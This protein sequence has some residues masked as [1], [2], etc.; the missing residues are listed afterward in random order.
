MAQPPWLVPQHRGTRRTHDLSR[1]GSLERQ[2]EATPRHGR[3]ATATASTPPGPKPPEAMEDPSNCPTYSRKHSEAHAHH[4]SGLSR[5]PAPFPHAGGAQAAVHRGQCSKEPRL[6]PRRHHRARHR[7]GKLFPTLIGWP[8]RRKTTPVSTTPTGT[9][10]RWKQRL[11]L[12][13]HSHMHPVHADH[14][15]RVEG[16]MRFTGRRRG[17]PWTSARV[18]RKPSLWTKPSRSPRLRRG[19]TIAC[20]V[21]NPAR[22]RLA[23][24]EPNRPSLDPTRVDR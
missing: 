13:S 23:Q 9:R 10:R 6:L 3:S 11:P 8:R 15:E 17:P 7:L 22:P 14:R 5:S 16:W 24:P 4:K 12:A 21:S 2:T 18:H 1:R 20:H 19:S